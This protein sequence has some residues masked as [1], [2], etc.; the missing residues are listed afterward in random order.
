MSELQQSADAMVATVR[1]MVER[2]QLVAGETKPG[3]LGDLLGTGVDTTGAVQTMADHVE[4]WATTQRARA[5]AGEIEWST[6]IRSGQIYGQD[7]AGITGDTWDASTWNVLQDTV[8]S[9]AAQLPAAIDAA[10]TIP[11]WVKIV[12]VAGVLA[13]LLIAARPYVPSVR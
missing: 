11:T 2:A 10:L 5:E 13:V 4:E 7:L 3:F 12:A 6:W 1:A 8:K 9:T